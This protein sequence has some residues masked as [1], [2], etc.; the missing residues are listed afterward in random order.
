MK[1]NCDNSNYRWYV[2][3]LA[4]ITLAFC[5]ACP[6]IC[7]SVLFNEI[8]TKL[9][10]NVVQVG[11]IWGFYPLSSVFTIFLAG[12]LADRFGA[13]RILIVSCILSG[14]AGASRGLAFD[15]ISLMSTT[16][17]LSSYLSRLIKF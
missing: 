10:L 15:F 3:S 8:S 11:W 2:I 12:I 16:F 14:L 6:Q 7:M 9:G 17:L 13:R 4:A 1:I 5:L